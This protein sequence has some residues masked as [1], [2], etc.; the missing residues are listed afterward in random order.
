MIFFLKNRIF[1]SCLAIFSLFFVINVTSFADEVQIEPV[2]IKKGFERGVI[3]VTNPYMTQLMHELT[4]D[5]SKQYNLSVS[6][7]LENIDQSIEKIIEGEPA[8][9]I[10]TEDQEAIENL[11][12]KGLINVF[13]VSNL[14]ENRLVLAIPKDHFMAHNLKKDYVFHK[15]IELVLKHSL[16][17]IVD[18]GADISGKIT[19]QMFRSLGLYE[20]A[21]EKT[22]K[23]Q[24]TS[25]AIFLASEAK[26]PT[27]VYKADMYGY[28]N[29]DL[30]DIPQEYYDKITL[31]VAIVADIGDS[32][33]ANDAKS[34]TDYLKSDF[35]KGLFSKYGYNLI[36]N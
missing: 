5:F 18:E 19:S 26:N 16:L 23:V 34:F 15:K 27:I 30:Y 3:I 2:G 4:D 24:N 11:K 22:I 17:T 1:L 9:I 36:E 20:M 12:Q 21:R 33:N 29:F 8:N 35:A 13:S 7:V 25:K 10:I 6:V 31:L 28:T 14:A 32:K